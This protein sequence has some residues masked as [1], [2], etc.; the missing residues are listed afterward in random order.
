MKWKCNKCE[1]QFDAAPGEGRGGF[2]SFEPPFCPKCGSE[3]V[4][5]LLTCDICDTHWPTDRL[6]SYGKLY[7][8]PGCKAVFKVASTEAINQIR[9]Y[10]RGRR[11]ITEIRQA[12]ADY[13]DE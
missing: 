8:C 1:T 13:L 11:S 5:Q 3:D 7:I 10:G 6:E 2:F 4:D 12:L 9:S